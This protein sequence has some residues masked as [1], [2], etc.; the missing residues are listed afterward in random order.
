M[1]IVE[2]I[3]KRILH[4]CKE[5]NMSINKL[6]KKIRSFKYSNKWHIKSKY[7]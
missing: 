3:G 2:M 5:K 1:D 6:A 4:L 7:K